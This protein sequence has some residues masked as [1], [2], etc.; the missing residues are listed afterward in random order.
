MLLYNV[1]KKNIF[2]PMSAALNSVI[3]NFPLIDV[4]IPVNKM[5][6][7]LKEV[8]IMKLY[9]ELKSI[10]KVH[11][12]FLPEK[13]HNF[14]RIT[15]NFKKRAEHFSVL[16]KP[17]V[18]QPIQFW[19]P[20]FVLSLG[21]RPDNTVVHGQPCAVHAKLS[22]TSAIP[23]E[24]DSCRNPNGVSYIECVRANGAIIHQLL[25]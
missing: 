9:G 16:L 4:K 7:I 20:L 19:Y 21:Y 17:P 3:Y 22:S 2:S 8:E 6:S 5:F 12:F 11:E 10:S 15:S 18:H 13:D 25:T 24:E 1:V 23:F 14:V